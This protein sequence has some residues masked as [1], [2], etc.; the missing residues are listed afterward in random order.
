MLLPLFAANYYGSVLHAAWV[1]GEVV[2]NRGNQTQ[3]LEAVR[4]GSAVTNT[5]SSGLGVTTS[6][7]GPK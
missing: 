3:V 2:G 5:K 1:G 4:A 6:R 7:P